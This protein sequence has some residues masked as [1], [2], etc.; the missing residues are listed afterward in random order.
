MHVH[1]HGT[2]RDLAEK[3]KPAVDLIGH[4]PPRNGGARP[5]PTGSNATAGT[6]TTVPIVKIIGHEGQQ[7]GAVYKITVGRRRHFIEGNGNHYRCSNGPEHL[8]GFCWNGC[9]SGDRPANVAMLEGEVQSV[10]KVLRANGL[11]IGDPL[12][13][14]THAEHQS[15]HHFSITGEK[16][17]LRSLRLGSSPRCIS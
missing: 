10:I 3:A 4:V 16:D 17:L 15:E 6:I 5:G 1:R 13:S 11:E 12:D 9:R 8:G 14:P 2:A 7:T